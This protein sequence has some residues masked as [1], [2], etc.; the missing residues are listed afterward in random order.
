[1][2]KRFEQAIYDA[3]GGDADVTD[4]ASALWYYGE[5][6]AWMLLRSNSE[7]ISDELIEAFEAVTD[8]FGPGWRVVEYQIDGYGG[9]SPVLLFGKLRVDDP[10]A[11]R[12]IIQL[13]NG[14]PGVACEWVPAD[15]VSYYIIPKGLVEQVKDMIRQANE[16]DQGE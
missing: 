13:L 4:V 3:L 1:M 12:M 6:D 11:I 2:R 5:L 14:N 7:N 9:H 8:A 10:R 15:R 16:D